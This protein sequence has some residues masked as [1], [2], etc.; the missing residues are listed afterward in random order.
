MTLVNDVLDERIRVTENGSLRLMNKRQA[1]VAAMVAKAIKGDVRAAILVVRLMEAHDPA[2][3]EGILTHEE[4][5]ESPQLTGSSI[6]ELKRCRQRWR[7]RQ[8][9][10]E[11]SPSSIPVVVTLRSRSAC[12]SGRRPQIDVSDVLPAALPRDRAA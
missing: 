1:I 7:A 10:R 4:W 2:A 3:V 12:R 6:Q 5:L 9:G 11:H 8:G